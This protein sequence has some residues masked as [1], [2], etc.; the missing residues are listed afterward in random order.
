MVIRD[1]T[2]AYLQDEDVLEAWMSECI[3]VSAQAF[4]GT[5]QLHGSYQ[6]WAER[7]REKFYGLKRF[8]QLLEERGHARERTTR[9]NGFRGLR[10]IAPDDQPRQPE[11]IE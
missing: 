9:A 3:E 4:T 10:L 2:N 5:K 6:S 7:S 1:A 8:G 11:L